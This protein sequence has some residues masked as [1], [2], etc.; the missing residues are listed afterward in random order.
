MLCVAIT[1]IGHSFHDRA[2]DGKL[3]R[4]SNHLARW[5]ADRSTGELEAPDAVT[6]PEP[7]SNV[8]ADVPASIE[9]SQGSKRYRPNFHLGVSQFATPSRE[10]RGSWESEQLSN[11]FAWRGGHD[12]GSEC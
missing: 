10:H 2:R 6:T 12:G 3:P 4:D 11:H 9:S 8:S 7:L 1:S 5:I